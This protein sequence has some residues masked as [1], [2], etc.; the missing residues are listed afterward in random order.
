MYPLEFKRQ[1]VERLLE[2]D[3]SVA[4][5]CRRNDIKSSTMYGWIIYFTEHEPEMFGGKDCI[6]PRT[7]KR[8]FDGT[9]LNMKKARSLAKA[10]E[11]GFIVL[12]REDLEEG[13]SEADQV[14][15]AEPVEVEAKESNVHDAEKED[16]SSS[17]VVKEYHSLQ[18]SSSQISDTLSYESIL[19]KK[20]LQSVPDP[21]PITMICRDCH[22]IIPQGIKEQELVTLLKAV[23]Y[24]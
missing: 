13:L 17:L 20:H 9:R 1:M 24:S 14:V 22:I 15:E 18:D 12:G 5:W 19:E 7:E 6:V 23:R 10:K 21:P 2:T 16:V 3:L 11:D 4:E 8:W